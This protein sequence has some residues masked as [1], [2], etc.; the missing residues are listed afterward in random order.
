MIEIDKLRWNA[1]VLRLSVA[2][3]VAAGLAEGCDGQADSTYQGEPLI[4]ISGQVEA[5]LSVGD[6]EVGVLW[7][8]STS[9][10]SLECTGEANADGAPSPCAE[11]CGEVTCEALEAWDACVSNCPDV[12]FAISN[13][14]TPM[15][16]FLTAG[17]GQT[18]A[19]IGEF[20]AQFSLDILEPPPPEALIASSTGEQ[21]GIGLFVALDPAGAPFRAD[22]SELRHLPGWVLGGSES[23]ILVFSP[24]G[25]PEGSVWALA[26]GPLESGFHLLAAIPSEED[27]VD[28]E[29]EIVSSGE[30]SQVSLRIA[31]ADSIAWPLPL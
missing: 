17:V 10:F 2:L 20:P 26:S 29:L 5:G 3:G 23:H 19:A 22:L 16:P 4:S 21:L 25:I 6:V 27:G 24:G 15:V 1:G 9:V 28:P 31:P 12:T 7:L 18:T 13:A 8:T 11:A 14:S 30:A